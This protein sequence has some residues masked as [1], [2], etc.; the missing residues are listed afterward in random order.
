MKTITLT[1]EEWEAIHLQELA[2]ENAECNGGND[3]RA[4]NGQTWERATQDFAAK[5]RAA[6]AT[7]ED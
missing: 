3:D 2:D 6:L 4:P 1:L 5:M 7:K